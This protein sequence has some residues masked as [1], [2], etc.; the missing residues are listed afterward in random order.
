MGALHRGHP[1]QVKAGVRRRF[2][3]FMVKSEGSGGSGASCVGFVACGA[4]WRAADKVNGWAGRGPTRCAR[5]PRRWSARPPSWRR[6]C[7]MV[8]QESTRVDD[9][10]HSTPAPVSSGDGEVAATPD[11]PP[12]TRHTFSFHGC[13]CSYLACLPD[14][15][16]HSPTSSL[17]PATPV[18]CVHGF[19]TLCGTGG[20]A[21]RR[22]FTGGAGGQLHRLPGGA[23]S[24]PQRARR[25]ETCRPCHRRG[26]LHQ[27]LAAHAARQEA[28]LAERHRRPGDDPPVGVSPLRHPLLCAAATS[29]RAAAHSLHCVRG[30]QPRWRCGRGGRR[31]RAIGGG[32]ASAGATTRRAGRVPGVHRLRPR[33][34]GRRAHR[35]DGRQ[36]RHRSASPRMHSVER[37]GPVGALP[38]RPRHLRHAAGRVAL[39]ALARSGTLPPRPGARSG[40]PVVARTAA[41]TA[42]TTTATILCLRG[43]SIVPGG[44]GHHGPVGAAVSL[45]LPG[46]SVVSEPTAAGVRSGS[47]AAAEAPA[48]DVCAAPQLGVCAGAGAGAVV[49]AAAAAARPVRAARAHPAGAA[50]G[51]HRCVHRVRRRGGGSAGHQRSEWRAV[52]GPRAAP[53]P[54]HG[55]VLRGVC[56]R[57][58]GVRASAPG[59]GGGSDDTEDDECFQKPGHRG[60]ARGCQTVGAA[61]PGALSQSTLPVSARAGARVA[62]ADQRGVPGEQLRPAAPAACIRGPQHPGGDGNDDDSSSDTAV[63]A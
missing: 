61:T 27:S 62:G 59:T 31:H 24:C 38:P 51:R 46:V 39:C 41:R 33:P 50:G 10:V 19:S 11:T 32:G 7:V 21:G 4:S 55:A 45:R 35:G 15:P 9:R 42:R 14:S 34:A 25:A 48:T 37:A 17:P 16:P 2:T 36:H 29:A 3:V 30:Q 47:A 20:D 5:L 13:R 57:R 63:G 60:G 8:G 40:Q 6:C 56:A 18:V 12:I 54:G 49:G 53:Q 44:A 43:L 22:R 23:T 26:D 1:G 52:A 58:R 28:Q